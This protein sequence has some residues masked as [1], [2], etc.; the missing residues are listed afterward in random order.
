MIDVLFFLNLVS[1]GVFVGVQLLVLDNVAPAVR[2]QEQPLSIRLH[3][4][5]LD[6]RQHFRLVMPATSVAITTAAVLLILDVSDKTRLFLA[7]G[8]VGM[9]GITIT[10][11][12]FNAPM[13]DRIRSLSDDDPDYQGLA[14]RWDRVHRLRALSG[15]LAICGF[16]VA[17]LVR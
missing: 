7:I 16:V 17:E 11:F 4:E 8:L 2:R 14:R 5:L 15:V 1:T 9:F 3:R 13:N 12:V 6:H 10:T